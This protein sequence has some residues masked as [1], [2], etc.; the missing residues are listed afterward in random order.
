MT[1]PLEIYSKKDPELYKAIHSNR[2]MAFSDGALPVKTK[3]LIALA[4]DTVLSAE[5]G[6]RHL[7]LT[8]LEAGAKK[9]EILDAVRVAYFI[10]GV[11]SAYTAAN[12]L[13]D[14]LVN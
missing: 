7:A 6:V 13:S 3:L 14:I 5:N 4:V 8:A 11:G 10:N 9:E 12:A 1:D 2:Q